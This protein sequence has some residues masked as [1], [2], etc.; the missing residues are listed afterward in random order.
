MLGVPVIEMP[1]TTHLPC[2]YVLSLFSPCVS[3]TVPFWTHFFLW[4]K[5]VEE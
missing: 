1:G 3:M 4:T 2:L 5:H